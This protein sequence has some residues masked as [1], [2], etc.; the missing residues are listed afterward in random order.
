MSSAIYY[1]INDR[2]QVFHHCE[3]S[4]SSVLATFT[5]VSYEGKN[6]KKKKDRDHAFKMFQFQKEVQTLTTGMNTGIKQLPTNF[7]SHFKAWY[8]LPRMCMLF[9]LRTENQFMRR[10]RNKHVSHRN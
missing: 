1:T 4:V 6:E 9:S 8:I 7:L 5:Q 2:N 10:K 3:T